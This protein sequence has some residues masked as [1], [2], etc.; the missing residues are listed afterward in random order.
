MVTAAV[1]ENKKKVVEG[2]AEE[3][4]TFDRMVKVFMSI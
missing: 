3:V 4:I 2:V 1:H